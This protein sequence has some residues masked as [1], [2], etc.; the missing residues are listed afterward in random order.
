MKFTKNEKQVLKLLLD[1]GRASDVDMANELKISTQAVGKIRKKLKDSRV[2]EGYSCNLNYEELGL[3][4]FVLCSI[5]FKEAF[6]ENLW[7]IKTMDILK[8]TSESI[9]SFIPSGSDTSLVMLSAFRDAK[10]MDRFFHLAK[11]KLYG[12]GEIVNAHSFSSLNFLKNNPKEL[13]KLVLDDKSI[14]PSFVVSE[15]KE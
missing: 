5:K 2:I 8:K 14:V 1:N 3:N 9:F 12:Y 10:E 11:S 15:K 7:E 4:N 13:F 6:T